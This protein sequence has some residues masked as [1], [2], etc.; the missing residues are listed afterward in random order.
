MY[1]LDSTGEPSVLVEDDAY[2]YGGCVPVGPYVVV[3]AGMLG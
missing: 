3:L 2:G 1:E